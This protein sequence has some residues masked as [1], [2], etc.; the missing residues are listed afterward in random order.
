ML[1]LLLIRDKM[2][3]GG[4][5]AQ[6]FSNKEYNTHGGAGKWY[7]TRGILSGNSCGGGVPAYNI[8]KTYSK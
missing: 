2:E 5:P 8:I 7:S 4:K 6:Q 1:F 3:Y